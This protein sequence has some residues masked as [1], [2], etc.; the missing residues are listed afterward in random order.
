MTLT[1]ALFYLMGAVAV[2]C[3]IAM[4]LSRNPVYSAIYLIGTLL[5]IAGIFMLLD[6]PLLAAL[7]VL[8]YTGAIMV[9]YLFVIMLLNL[10]RI[11]GFRWWANWRTYAGAILAGLVGFMA[12]RRARPQVIWAPTGFSPASV[13]DI[14]RLMF[15]NPTLLFLVEAISVL[16]LMAVVGAIY[17]G[18]RRDPD[19]EAAA[20]TGTDDQPSEGTA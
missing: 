19:E 15:T 14:A 17:L 18:R 6:A 20:P 8:V 7:Q 2:A 12:L 16:L 10:G 4:L 1:L 3:G 13:Q 9:L 5:S 11:P